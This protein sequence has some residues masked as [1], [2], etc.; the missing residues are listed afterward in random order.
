MMIIDTWSSELSLT[1]SEQNTEYSLSDSTSFFDKVDSRICGSLHQLKSPSNIPFGSLV[2]LQDMQYI[3]GRL[4][5]A[6]LLI[7]QLGGTHAKT[8]ITLRDSSK[9]C[10]ETAKIV[11]Q[12]FEKFIFADIPGALFFAGLEK[13]QSLRNGCS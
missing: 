11:T 3:V 5:A 7:N 6:T 8:S 2:A 13:L 10:D 1:R 12:E 4:S 9:V